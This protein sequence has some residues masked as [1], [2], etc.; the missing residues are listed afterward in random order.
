MEGAMRTVTVSPKYQIVIPKEIRE[1]MGIEPGE[2]A[3]IIPY[4]H[5]LEFIPVRAAKKMR[6]L[7]KGIDTTVKR[8]K[9]QK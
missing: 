5:R 2:K 6:G 1:A 8:D 9:D 4:E 3:Q 7:L